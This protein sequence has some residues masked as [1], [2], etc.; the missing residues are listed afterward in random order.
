MA[1]L[2]QQLLELVDA[3]APTLEKAFLDA[4]DDI[5]SEI[6][7][8][9]VIEAL[10]RR[11]AEAAIEALHIDPAAFRPLSEAVREAF[12]QGGSLVIRNLPGLRNP[13][14]GRV[15]VR[16]D[17]SN[18]R[19]EAVIRE[20]SSTLISGIEEGT[21]QL[22]REKIAAGFSQGQG[23][24]AI[25]LDLAGRQSRT[26]GLREG[27]LIGMTPRLGATVENARSA[28]SAGDVKGM[29]K[30]LTLERRDRRFDRQVMKAIKDGIALAPE[31]VQRIT[32]RLSDRY[33]KLRAETIAST[34][35]A[36]SANAAQHEAYLQMLDRTGRDPSLV[37]RQ[38]RSA[39]DSRVRHTHQALNA[40]EVTGMDAPFQ[41]PS[42]ALM[43]FPG[44]ASLGAG[45]AEVIG[46]RCICFYSFDFAES[47]ARSRGR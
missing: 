30:Y 11:D 46:C 38:W 16:W 26:T 40:T 47:F 35:T 6:V 28:L 1:T 39:G 18:Q 3:L 7:L 20:Q 36:M 33:V 22:A 45:P 44:D 2:R 31:V 9:E 29:V 15:V 37:T 23:P 27:G 8:R 19:A 13:M 21:R 4:I 12:N 10:E 17:G 32:G 14:G 34:E 25:A 42:G 41:S 5:K 24:R 43:R